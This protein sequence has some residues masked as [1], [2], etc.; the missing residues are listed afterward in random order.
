MNFSVR[1]EW[2]IND[3]WGGWC[4][5]IFGVS[6]CNYKLIIVLYNCIE[7]YMGIFIMVFFVSI[8]YY[9]YVNIIL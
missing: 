3:L 2:C 1:V 9:L 6:M 8:I 4:M 5:V 7:F